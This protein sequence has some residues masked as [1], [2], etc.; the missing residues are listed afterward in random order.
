MAA[1]SLRGPHVCASAEAGVDFKRLG[2]ILMAAGGV[3]LAGAL[4]WWFTFY[5]S[6]ARDFSRATGGRG[7]ASIFDAWTCLYSSSGTCGL[8]AGIASFTG[9]TVYEPMVFWLGLAGLIAGLVI[10][11]AAKP[12]SR[13]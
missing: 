12:A 1:G 13:V 11:L 3:V 7:D 8:V 6:L 9:K 10:R 2:N 5:S 4:I